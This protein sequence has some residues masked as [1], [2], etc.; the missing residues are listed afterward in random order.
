MKRRRWEKEWISWGR[1]G[2]GEG[3][4]KEW[5]VSLTRD[6]SLTREGKG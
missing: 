4:I 3:R 1:I 2:G 5:T 6:H